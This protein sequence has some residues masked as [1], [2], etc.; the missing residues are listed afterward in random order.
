MQSG[1]NEKSDFVAPPTDLGAFVDAAY[2]LSTWAAA[3]NWDGSGNTKEWLAELETKIELVQAM[4]PGVEAEIAN[5][6][7]QS[8]VEWR[9]V[10][11]A[12]RNKR[13]IVVSK[14]FPEPHEAMLYDN[15]WHTWGVSGSYKD[16]PYLWTS[17]PEP[18]VGTVTPESLDLEVETKRLK[19][20]YPHL[21][22]RFAGPHADVWSCDL[23]TMT[24]LKGEWGVYTGWGKSKVLALLDARAKPDAERAEKQARERAEAALRQAEADREKAKD[25]EMFGA[26]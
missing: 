15:G 12:P 26:I 9:D 1:T 11:T 21:S 25:D 7:A 14:R 16:D 19:A 4:T 8:L 6:P 22:T 20:D 2:R 17:L 23:T 18:P 5:S 24:L 10:E 3:I 13:V